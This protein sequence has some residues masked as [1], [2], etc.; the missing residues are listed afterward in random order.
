MKA[1]MGSTVTE[2]INETITT[3]TTTWDILVATGNTSGLPIGQVAMV[4]LR[5][6]TLA[7]ATKQRKN[8]DTKKFIR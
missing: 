7:V 5:P 3:V 4:Q 1:N 8:M 6:N 2:M